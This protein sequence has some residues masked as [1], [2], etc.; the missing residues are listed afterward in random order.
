V[1]G[2]AGAGV[3]FYKKATC[4]VNFIITALS[5]S[6]IAPH[7]ASLTT[8]YVGSLDTP[9]LL[10]DHG[11]TK[12]QCTVRKT[13]RLY[14]QNVVVGVLDSECCVDDEIKC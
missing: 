4:H 8:V 13:Q 6:L 11:G 1:G 10:G 12:Y 9:S 3:E 7:L 14:I 2:V 5:L